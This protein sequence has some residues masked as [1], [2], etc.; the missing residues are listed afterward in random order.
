MAPC[1]APS[2]STSLVWMLG[3]SALYCSSHV[4][5]TFQRAFRRW[6]VGNLW[7]LHK[8]PE[9]QWLPWMWIRPS[10]TA[11]SAADLVTYVQLFGKVELLNYLCDTLHRCPFKAFIVS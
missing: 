6:R 3:G 4:P 11:A 2:A 10:F 8:Q 9:R 5:V 7:R 1:I